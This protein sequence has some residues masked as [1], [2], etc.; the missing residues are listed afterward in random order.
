MMSARNC[1]AAGVQLLI[2]HFS[3][4]PQYGRRFAFIS[5]AALMALRLFSKYMLQCVAGCSLCYKADIKTCQ[6]CR[7]EYLAI[8]SE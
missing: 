3:L 1:S 2:D 6:N 5:I 7:A 8:N 4:D